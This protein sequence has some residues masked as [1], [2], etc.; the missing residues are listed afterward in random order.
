MHGNGPHRLMAILLFL[1]GIA[2]IPAVESIEGHQKPANVPADAVWVGGIDGGV[3]VT[4]KKGNKEKQNIYFGV[5]YY[6]SGE[7][8]YKGRL[9]LEPNGQPLPEPTPPDL[10]SGW[11]GERLYLQDGRWLSVIKK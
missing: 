10:L 9:S 7:I 2:H 5:I 6:E 8:G 4:L 3:F 1:L 11:D